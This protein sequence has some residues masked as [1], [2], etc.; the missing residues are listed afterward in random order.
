MYA[1]RLAESAITPARVIVS[2]P[3]RPRP[4]PHACHRPPP[5][6]PAVRV[7]TWITKGR[8]IVAAQC[9]YLRRKL[10]DVICVI[11]CRQIF[12]SEVREVLFSS[13]LG[14]IRLFAT[15]YVTDWESG[16]GVCILSVWFIHLLWAA[17][18][19]ET[20]GLSMS[21]QKKDGRMRVRAFPVSYSMWY[22]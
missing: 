16:A 11:S 3:A 7:R 21:G 15:A 14:L 13:I 19:A 5:A 1:F 17:S 2:S 6:P 12:K 20:W 4:A 10:P 9:C 18:E 8:S 22:S